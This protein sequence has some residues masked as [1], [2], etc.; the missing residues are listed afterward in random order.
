MRIN[1]KGLKTGRSFPLIQCQSRSTVSKAAVTHR[2]LEKSNLKTWVF[3]VEIQHGT[4]SKKPPKLKIGGQSEVHI[5]PNH[6]EKDKSNIFFLFNNTQ[7]I[8]PR[9]TSMGR[10]GKKYVFRWKREKSTNLLLPRTR[11]FT[12]QDINTRSYNV[13]FFFFSITYSPLEEQS[14]VCN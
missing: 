2:I 13:D 9:Y 3:Q 14:F 5:I 1:K 12:L 11:V 6:K 4:W 8:L 10:W 7:G